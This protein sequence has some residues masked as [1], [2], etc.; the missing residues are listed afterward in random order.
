MAEQYHSMPYS[1]DSPA[2]PDAV[3]AS[4]GELDESF[5]SYCHPHLDMARWQASLL[6]NTTATTQPLVSSVPWCNT[7]T[8][9]PQQPYDA[10]PVPS[11]GNC[12]YEE[13]YANSEIVAWSTTDDSTT[14][15]DNLS[16]YDLLSQSCS[17]VSYEGP[18]TPAKSYSTSPTAEA[19]YNAPCN[20]PVAKHSPPTSAPASAVDHT[21]S[22]VGATSIDSL[23]LAI[24]ASASTPTSVATGDN[25]PRAPSIPPAPSRK[26]KKHLCHYPACHKSFAQRTHLQIHLRAHSGEKPFLCRFARCGQRFSQLGNLRT[27]ERRHTGERPFVCEREGCGKRFPQRGN[28]RSHIVTVHGGDGESEGSDC[29]KGGGE[30]E[31]ETKAVKERGRFVC[32]LDECAASPSSRAEPSAPAAAGAGRFFTQLGNLKAHQN[33]FHADTLQRWQ[34]RFAQIRAAA[35]GDADAALERMSETE[36][37]MWDY[38]GQLYRNCNKGIKGRGKGRRVETIK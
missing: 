15:A 14:Q 32:L 3:A 30:E 36:R 9:A 8:S 16:E 19:P 28:L 22:N 33:K 4:R 17:T 13:D 12:E 27:H 5:W 10:F 2:L 23:M 35:G 37:R 21:Q 34:E 24:Q 20:Q 38:F 25:A 26:L 29:V 31:E 1:T 7:L 11:Y 18:S 6:Y